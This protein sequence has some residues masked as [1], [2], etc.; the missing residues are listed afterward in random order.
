MTSK[1]LYFKLMKEDLKRRLWAVSLITLGFFFLYPVV[2]AFTAGN[3]KDLS[4]YETYEKALEHYAQQLIGWLSFENGMTVFVMVLVSLICGLSGFSYLNSR[5]KVDF[6]HSIPVR[7]ER[8]YL[9]NYVNGI[10]IVAVPYVISIVLAVIVGIANGVEGVRLWSVAFP[11]CGLH[12]TYFIL[13]Y[14]TVVIAAMMTGNLIIGILGSI[15]LTFYIPLATS[16]TNGLFTMFF[17][18]YDWSRQNTSF[19]ILVRLSPVVEYIM[20]V[21][22]YAEGDL[23]LIAVLMALLVSAVLAALGCIL[24]KKRPSESAGKAMAFAVTCP[25]IRILIVILSSIGFGGFFWSL[26]ESTGWMVFG[27][28]CGAMIAHCVIEIIYYFD[29]KKLFG[30]KRQLLACILISVAV[31]FVFCYDIFGYDTYMPKTDKVKYASVHVDNLNNWTSYGT[32]QPQTDGSYT[33]EDISSVEYIRDHMQYEDVE[34]VLNIA[35]SGVENV[36]RDRE[37]RSRKG[38]GEAVSTRE[39][40]ADKND[41]IYSSVGICYTLNSGRKVYRR[42]NINLDK[43]MPHMERLY[44]SEQY[45][46][47]TF[48]LMSIPSDSVAAVR[49]K[50]FIKANRTSRSEVSVL[51]TLTEAEKKELLETYQDEFK[52]MTLQQMEQEIPVGGIR[53]SVM[54][55]EAAIAWWNMVSEE[56]YKDKRMYGTAFTDYDYYPVYSSFEK[57]IA[58]LEKHHLEISKSFADFDVISVTMTRD[59][60]ENREW[61][62]EKV[63][64]VTAPEEIEELCRVMIPRSGEYYN[65]LFKG[66]RTDI[67]VQITDIEVQ[68]DREGKKNHVG[69]CFPKASVPEFVESEFEKTRLSD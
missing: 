11:A 16:L 49:Y 38:Y 53:F 10:L 69:A 32:F 18:T 54:D 33:W 44:A 9:V 22:K 61:K 52:S 59:V 57:T 45:H 60:V 41:D 21:G 42:Y 1:N 19:D 62:G 56:G 23:S 15:V 14:S 63:V 35:A 20:Q 67:E 26:R 12:L 13:M 25:V 48:P 51:N 2:A 39:R 64:T 34:N 7:R 36:R 68:R 37:Q 66:D 4:I 5:R 24:Y 29:F 17:R 47:G 27:V 55:S 28:L 8:L 50:D 43:N 31:L 30:H 6:Y 65:N 3:I 46:K 40:E 58:L